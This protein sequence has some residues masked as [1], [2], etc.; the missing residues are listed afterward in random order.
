[1]VLISLLSA[2]CRDYLGE[3]PD[4]R[5]L[6]NDPKQ[7]AELLVSA[8]PGQTY[9]VFTELMSDNSGDKG[10]S[11]KYYKD[12]NKVNFKDAYSWAGR[13]T[14]EEEITDT[15]KQYWNSCFKAIAAANQALA[16]ID[17]WGH[18]PQTDPYRGEALVARAY[19][20]FMLVN[21]W[22]K[23]YN[24]ATAAQDPGI[25]IVTKVER[26]VFKDYKRASVQEV[27]DFIEKDLEAGIPLIA[28]EA[29]QKPKFHFTKGAAHAFATRFYKT[30]G[31]WEQVISHADKV[32]NSGNYEI[33]DLKAGRTV[34]EL[35]ASFMGA[36][37]RH[38]LL[39]SC[40]NSIIRRKASYRH[41]L[42][43]PIYDRVKER[44]TGPLSSSDWLYKYYGRSKFT[45]L[46]K[47]KEYFFYTAEHVGEAYALI[48]CFRYEEVLLNRA[49][50]Y[51]M[52]GNTAAA[53]ADLNRLYAQRVEKFTPVTASA[54]DK[55]YTENPDF[56]QP[57]HPFY[58][59]PD[60]VKFLIQAIV[61]ATR[62]E[63][64]GEGLRWF[65]IRRFHIPIEHRN[66]DSPLPDQ[67]TPTRLPGDSPKHC[68]QI[69]ENASPPLKPNPR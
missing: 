5:T 23:T 32:I 53:V 52:T 17:K 6:I 4:N 59:I 54:I 26:T 60:H 34:S 11:D 13:F 58:E 38:N 67:Q 27:F 30:K 3:V 46:G 65:D 55:Y 44:F 33:F 25:P 36:G 14:T 64:L 20:H 8:Y 31:D 37:E 45:N 69:P 2:S 61:D 63:F 35:K 15:P 24:P 29:Y 57:L 39:I 22:A 1:M 68:L 49:E 10:P 19:A 28:D 43:V 66:G 51:A 7:I 47:F 62:A 12:R 18:A 50:A 48:A 21:L 40:P 56:V 9:A 42:S 16:S 41:G